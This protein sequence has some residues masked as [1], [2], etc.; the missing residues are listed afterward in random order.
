MLPERS[1]TVA[2]LT[3]AASGT[4]AL[5]ITS[6]KSCQSEVIAGLALARRECGDHPHFVDARRLADVDALDVVARVERT[7]GDGEPGLKHVALEDAPGVDLFHLQVEI[8]HARRLLLLGASRR[9][10]SRP[11]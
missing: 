7:A 3:G 8:V 2:T 9:R 10:R 5:S 4:S 1:S 11:A 6:A